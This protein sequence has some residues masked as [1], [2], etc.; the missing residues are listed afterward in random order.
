MIL[1]AFGLVV[2]ALTKGGVAPLSYEGGVLFAFLFAAIKGHVCLRQAA[3][4]YWANLAKADL[5][6]HPIG[7]RHVPEKPTKAHWALYF[8]GLYGLVWMSFGYIALFGLQFIIERLERDALPQHQLP[9]SV[10]SINFRLASKPLAEDEVRELVRSKFH[11]AG[12]TDD[13]IVNFWRG[14]IPAD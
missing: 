10:K 3:S 14:Y 5:H 11:A 13:E 7:Q 1:L 2:L 4:F 8:L 9:D 6:F 12:F